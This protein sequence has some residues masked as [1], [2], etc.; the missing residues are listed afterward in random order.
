MPNRI[1]VHPFF[2]CSGVGAP[3]SFFLCRCRRC[4][5][6]LPIWRLSLLTFP[7]PHHCTGG[8]SSFSA[9]IRLSACLSGE[10]VYE[11]GQEEDRG[12]HTSP[13]FT[14]SSPLLRPS[15]L[16]ATSACASAMG[17]V[18]LRLSCLP[19]RHEGNGNPLIMRDHL[20]ASFHTGSSTQS[21]AVGS[22]AA[23]SLPTRCVGGHVWDGRYATETCSHDPRV[24]ARSLPVMPAIP[25]K[26]IL[27]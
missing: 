6:P 27:L 22:Q 20:R 23:C 19:L 13:P 7:R 2:I 5:L 3:F 25:L 21:R 15:H 26:G 24:C 8:G 18:W 11:E 16:P 4:P 1:Q 14:F 17:L 10:G 12:A 9:C